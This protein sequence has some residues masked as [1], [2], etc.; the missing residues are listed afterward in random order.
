M[1]LFGRLFLVNGLQARGCNSAFDSTAAWLLVS[2]DDSGSQCF[3][4]SSAA[5]HHITVAVVI[6]QAMCRRRRGDCDDDT[7]VAAARSSSLSHAFAEPAT[8][9]YLGLE[10]L[11][12][13]GCMAR[14]RFPGLETIQY[15]LNR[16]ARCIGVQLGTSSQE[17]NDDLISPWAWRKCRRRSTRIDDNN[18][19][20]RPA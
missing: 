10:F 12:T 15:C 19:P 14:T 9:T 18:G 11:S 8:A 7:A 3:I 2:W 6:E 16:Q 13:R 5:L 20:S 17:S 1:A 4:A